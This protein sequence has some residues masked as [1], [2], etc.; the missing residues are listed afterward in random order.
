MSACL[1]EEEQPADTLAGLKYCV[2]GLGNRQ[3]EHYNKMGR[4]TNEKLAAMGAKLVYSTSHP[5]MVQAPQHTHSHTAI[6][7]TQSMVREM[8]TAR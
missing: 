5:V 1:Q 6:F 2:F 7:F 8:M 4:L 3:Y